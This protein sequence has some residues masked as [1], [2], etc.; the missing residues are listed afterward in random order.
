MRKHMFTGLLETCCFE[1]SFLTWGAEHTFQVS[2][3]TKYG[4]SQWRI[5]YSICSQNI[6]STHSQLCTK[7]LRNEFCRSRKCQT[8]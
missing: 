8:G 1:T 2:S 6:I 4:I 7:G 3:I 5:P